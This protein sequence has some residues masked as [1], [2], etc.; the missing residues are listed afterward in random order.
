M[1]S[2]RA[3]MLMGRSKG[4]FRTFWAI[5]ITRKWL[6]PKTRSK[7]SLLT[8]FLRVI[9]TF[10]SSKKLGSTCSINNQATSPRRAMTLRR[11]RVPLKTLFQY[12]KETKTCNLKWINLTRKL[13]RN[14][15][16]PETGLHPKVFTPK[17]SKIFY[18]RSVRK[19]S[20][21]LKKESRSIWKSQALSR[22]QTKR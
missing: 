8:R 18:K 5:S 13:K 12:L 11:N 7:T 4:S 16:L 3:V 9:I 6:L 21:R 20:R 1:E 17:N 19:N 15:G 10:L 22:K 14:L 2:K